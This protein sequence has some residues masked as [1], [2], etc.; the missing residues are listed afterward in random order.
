MK[1]K[2]SIVFAITFISLWSCKKDDG[3]EI[4]V[5]PPRSLIEVAAE[6][7]AEILEFL[8]TH[9]FNYEDF[10]N[11]Q[12]KFDYKIKFDTIAGENGRK[13]S[14]LDSG[15]LPGIEFGVETISVAS[16]S[17]G[18]DDGEVADHKLYYL[19]A[20]QGS[21]DFPTIGDNSILRYEGL[22]LN[23]T[24][25]DG[26]SN[27]PLKFYLSNP[28]L[29][30]GFAQAILKLKTGD[31]FTDN[32][33]G[34]VSFENYGVGVAFMPSGLAYFNTRAG[35]IPAYSPLIFKLDAIAYEKDTDYDGDGIPSILEDLNGDGNLNNDNTDGDFSNS[36]PVYNHL[37]TDDDGDGIPT[38]EEINLDS[39]GKFE[40][41]RDSDGDG[42]PDHLD[43]DS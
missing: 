35:S 33:D 30:V 40:S 36:G 11:P 8:S 22:L 21:G 10:L 16:S 20:R 2:N 28:G 24:L 7:D 4:E 32:G 43:K 34:T 1:L 19:I 31:S 6:D 26:S 15:E 37:D 18:I 27:Q 39:E 42:I 12:E 3:P 13:T 29:R 38:I 14:I 25:F 9:F 23:G 41:V 17:F 5:V